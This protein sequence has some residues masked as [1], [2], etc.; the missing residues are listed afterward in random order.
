MERALLSHLTLN[1][2]AFLPVE[3]G[4]FRLG[5]STCDQVLS[6]STIIKVGFQKKTKDGNCLGGPVIGL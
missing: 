4:G 1:L 2:E 5:H 6:L 3:Q